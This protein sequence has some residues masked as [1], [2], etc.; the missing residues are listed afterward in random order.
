VTF[1]EPYKININH[2]SK[3]FIKYHIR[4][5]FVGVHSIQRI[6]TRRPGFFPVVLQK[7]W[8][9]EKIGIGPEISILVLQIGHPYDFQ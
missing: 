2:P 9:Q 6:Y 8:L 1:L 5:A 7:N 3:I 4:L